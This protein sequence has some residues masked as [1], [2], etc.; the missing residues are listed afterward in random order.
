MA[1]RLWR[2]RLFHRGVEVG[3]IVGHGRGRA[4]SRASARHATRARQDSIDLHRIL[5]R[6]YIR[7][8]NI[9]VAGQ[10][11]E[12]GL[13]A[14]FTRSHDHD[15][16]AKSA[17]R[18]GISWRCWAPRARAEPML[19]DDGL[20]KEPWFLESFLELADDLEG[21]HKE[22]KRFVDHVGAQGLPLLQGDAFRQFRASATSPT[23]SRR[24]SRCCN[25]TSSARA[26]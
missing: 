14:W 2:L 13:P 11:G 21:A 18:R 4:A 1:T 7:I 17:D 3:Q 23:T 9:S 19:T 10:G 16:T 24:I 26:R 22:G 25:S 12:A 6:R 15:D 5:T 8:E 20:Y